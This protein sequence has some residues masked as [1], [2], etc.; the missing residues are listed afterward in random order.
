M[1]RATVDRIF[2]PFFS[3]KGDTGTGLG[4]WIVDSITKR[5][6]GTIRVRSRTGRNSGTVFSVFLPFDHVG[7]GVTIASLDLD[8]SYLPVRGAFAHPR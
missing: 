1:E 6:G 7:K 3:T 2:Q 8:E 5:H 4:L